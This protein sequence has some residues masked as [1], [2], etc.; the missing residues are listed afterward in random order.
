[1]KDKHSR[2][3]A[4]C[5]S[6]SGDFYE[7]PSEECWFDDFFDTLAYMEKE[8]K[9]DITPKRVF[10]GKYV[11]NKYGAKVKEELP[12]NKASKEQIENERR[13]LSELLDEITHFKTLAITKPDRVIIRNN[14]DI[15]FETCLL[16]C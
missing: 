13:R 11:T 6:Y 1:M 3:I 9:K 8:V 4:G 10:T 2:Y 5:T 7:P 12:L 14:T 15:Y 16:H